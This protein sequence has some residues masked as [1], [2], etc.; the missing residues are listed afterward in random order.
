MDSIIP[1]FMF[2]TTVLMLDDNMSFLENLTMRLNSN[3]ILF[4]EP[5]MALNYI[6]S[7][8][9]N[10]FYNRI[11]KYVE[12]IETSEIDEEGKISKIN[13]EYIYNQI[14]NKSRFSEISVIVVDYSMPT[15]N[16]RLFC[17]KIRNFPAKKIMLTGA[18]DNQ[19]A[20]DAFNA[21]LIDTFIVKD[22]SS[23]EQQLNAAIARHSQNYFNDL[24]RMLLGAHESNLKASKE[25]RNIFDNY[26][27][28]NKIN[29]YYQ[30]DSIGSYL[31]LADNGTFHWLVFN[32]AGQ[33]DE[34]ANIIKT[35]NVNNEVLSALTGKGK[36]LF[37]F[38]EIEKKKSLSEWL[39]YIFP[40]KGSLMDNG[41]L[42]Y[43]TVIHN[44]M[45]SI[46]PKNMYLFRDYLRGQNVESLM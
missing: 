26:L 6:L 14:Y 8:D 12:N 32:T 23:V 25:Y 38:S 46:N 20:V 31:G 28:D 44:E 27:I 43:Y 24:S 42:Y 37:L 21:G 9:E 18:A 3:T 10:N 16:G 35:N 17:E 45:F 36:M 5:D 33:I 40:I 2:P 34:I 4:S 30:L 15:T 39:G 11:S 29:E 7:R 19:I 22:A 13:Y 1:Y 41:E